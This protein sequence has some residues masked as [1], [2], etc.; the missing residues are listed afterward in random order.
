MSFTRLQPGST[1]GQPSLYMGDNPGTEKK[2]DNTGLVGNASYTRGGFPFG[3]MNPSRVV[4]QTI[5]FQTNHTINYAYVVRRFKSGFDKA[6]NVG[7]IV[8]IRKTRPPTEGNARMHTMMN[9]PQ[10]NFYLAKLTL[11]DKAPTMN[12]ILD[13]WAPQGIVQGEIGGDEADQP[14]E[15][16]LNLTVAGR[17]RTFNIFKDSCPDG[18]P[19]YLILKKVRMHLGS[20][21]VKETKTY[22][23]ALNGTAS[24]V[25]VPKYAFQF[26]GYADNDAHTPNAAALRGDDGGAYGTALYLGR[27]S[28]NARFAKTTDQHTTSAHSDIQKHVTL[29]MLE[30][31]VDYEEVPLN[32]DLSAKDLNQ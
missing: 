15:R 7:Q 14:Q 18:T 27:V 5:G 28:H 3:G 8:F 16:L 9:L 24:H 4:N 13:E 29:P 23:V 22:G 10:M 6:L 30:M 31:F 2:N 20:T 12:D 19:L 1:K 11:E 21:D 32:M 25:D 26:V 17:V